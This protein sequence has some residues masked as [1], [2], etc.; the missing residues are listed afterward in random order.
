MCE[1]FVNKKKMCDDENCEKCFNKS[2]I[3]HEKSLYWSDKNNI[4]PRQ[5]FKGSSNTY[6]FNCD[7]CNHLLS[8]RIDN[9][10]YC[11]NWCKYCSNQSLCNDEN[12]QECFNKSFAS[13]EKSIYWSEKNNLISRNVFKSTT[14]NS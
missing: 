11:N 12:C 3:S 5:I 8:L 14:K 2:F 4:L 13:H 9:I 10:V 1:K 7:K 6:Y